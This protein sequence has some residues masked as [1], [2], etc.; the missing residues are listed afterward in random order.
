MMLSEALE[1]IEVGGAP[2]ENPPIGGI[3]VDSR[4]VRPGDLFVAL[5]GER[6]DGHDFLAQAARAGAVAAVVERPVPGVRLPQYVVSS[7]WAA[8]AQVAARFYGDPSARLSVIGV[9]GT[10]GKTTVSYLLE[11]I[12]V[13]AGKTPA[14]VGTINY[15][16][17]GEVIR[18]GLTTPFPHELQEFLAA[19]LA[20]GASHVA[21]EVSSHSLAQGRVA[22]VRFDGAIF[23]NLSRDHLDYHGDMEN[24]FAAKARLFREF[25]PAGGKGAQIAVNVDDP[26]GCRL[27]REFPSALTFGF[28]TEALVR[29]RMTRM[30][31]EGTRVL[32]ATPAG[33]LSLRV[34]LIGAYN[35]SNVMA[36]V[37]GALLLGI[38][39][40]AVRE[41]VDRLGMI[42][43]RVETIP[44]DRG[45]R[46]CVDYA[47]T[48][49]GLDRLLSALRGTAAGR[50]IAVFGCG[51]NRD[52]G[53]RPEMGRVAARRADV[54]IVTSDNPRHEDP[55]AIIAD[56]VPGL[57]AEGFLEACGPVE[58]ESGYYEV[59]P[60]RRAAIA[61][62]LAVAR[63][64]DT[65]VIAGKGHENVQIVGDRSVPFE[66]ARVVRE[67]LGGRG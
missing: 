61:R 65:V 67:L 53:K 31:S 27:F 13:A 41:G 56:I 45:L 49:D 26:Y 35:V 28:A 62:A 15:R 6:V 12:F 57:R 8:L 9:T 11:S 33:D 32:L 34:R 66:D 37:C 58:W 22:G 60:D 18:S 4:R 46:V 43:G 14:V 30:E 54:V 48:P 40:D 25:L 5:R 50:L 1:G 29:P 39:A 24:Y 10:N 19:A 64:K 23:T 44:N 2:V 3:A 17:G 52:R 47:H 59:V 51:G 38:P 55:S 16:V 21:M 7:S 36:A 20:R 63:P 42:P